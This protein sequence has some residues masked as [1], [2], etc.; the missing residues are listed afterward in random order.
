MGEPLSREARHRIEAAFGVPVKDTYSNTEAGY[1]ASPCPSGA[2][3]H[4]HAENAIVEV[5]DAND[6][7]CLPGQTGRLVFTSLHNFL[8]PFI[9][10]DILD[11]V[12]L[13]DGPCPCGR[14][15]P[16]W[17]Q[18]DGR[19]HPL[20]HLADGRRKSSM[21]ITLGIRKVGGVHQ[22]QIVQRAVDHVII[23]VVPDRSWHARLADRMRSVVREEC[24]APIQVDVE[25]HE[26]LERSPGG[27]LRVVVI[28]MTTETRPA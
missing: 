4:A 17:T 18:V 12:T 24:E 8:T 1:L 28:E 22:F 25:E 16:L 26:S 10:Y 11:D 6:Q 9:R 5:L 27:K 3:L 14:G 13:A 19:R 2:G 7:P 21:G 15:L 20:L 23:R